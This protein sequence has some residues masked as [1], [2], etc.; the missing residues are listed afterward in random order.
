M[1]TWRKE[2]KRVLEIGSKTSTD[3]RLLCRSV[4]ADKNEV[5]LLD[6]LVYVRGEKEVATTCFFD[7][8]V[9]ARFIDG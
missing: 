2:S 9:K 4:D 7:N 6:G 5:R 1:T 3:T 8:V